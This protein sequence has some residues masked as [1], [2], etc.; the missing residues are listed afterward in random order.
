MRRLMTLAV[1]V[2]ASVILM[3]AIAAWL[4]TRSTT[5]TVLTPVGAIVVAEPGVWS[6]THPFV[7]LFEF[8]T[9]KRSPEHDSN[10]QSYFEREYVFAP[11]LFCLHA[12]HWVLIGAAAFLNI[13]VWGLWWRRRLKDSPG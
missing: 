12:G 3:L 5:F 9:V 8:T 6:M 2:M 11:P 4:A 13:C 7:W 1:R 10:L